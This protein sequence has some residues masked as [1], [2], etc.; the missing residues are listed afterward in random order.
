[1]IGSTALKQA[2]RF[3]LVDPSQGYATSG[4]SPHWLSP[5]SD[6]YAE[7]SAIFFDAWKLLNQDEDY[8]GSTTDPELWKANED[9]LIFVKEIRDRLDLCRVIHS[10]SESI[11]RYTQNTT[12]RRIS[13][14]STVWT[15]GFPVTNT[16]IVFAADPRAPQISDLD[17]VKLRSLAY[18]S[19]WYNDEASRRY[20]SRDFIG[21]QID[22]GFRLAQHASSRFLIISLDVAYLLSTT[23]FPATIGRRFSDLNIRYLGARELKGVLSGDGYPI[24]ALDL[25]TR[26]VESS[27]YFEEEDRLAPRADGPDQEKIKVFCLKFYQIK[28]NYFFVP[29]I[30]GCQYNFEALPDRYYST[31]DFWRTRWELERERFRSDQ[32]GDAYAE[33]GQTLVVDPKD[34][35]E[36]MESELGV[37]G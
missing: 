33:K 26:M 23:I 35:T 4:V 3:P 32:K 31:L 16:E 7:F 28:E 11:Q 5:I 2:A 17:D 6:F 12:K 1:M 22:V 9:E 8:G 37:K 14:K 34:V 29:F 27:H 36:M 24:F 19:K 30:I 21:P 18:L 15:A 20:L 10:W 25:K 13:V